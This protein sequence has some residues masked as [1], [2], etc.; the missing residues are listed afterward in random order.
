MRNI[1]SVLLWV[2]VLLL[3]LGRE[4]ASGLVIYRLGGEELPPPP[5]ADDPDV[6]FVQL[7]WSEVDAAQGGEIYQLDVDER[8]IRALEY[9]PQ[10]NVAPTSVDR[11]GKPILPALNGQVWDGDTTTVWSAERY[12]CIEFRGTAGH[13]CYEDFA[14]SG[15]TQIILGDGKMVL[16][17]VRILSGLDDP[18]GVVRTVRLFISSVASMPRLTSHSHPPARPHT[19]EIRNNSDPRLEI[20]LPPH[21]DG[22][23]LQVALGEHDHPWK[24]HDIEVYAKGFVDRSTY[25]SNRIDAQDPVAWGEIRWVGRKA[26]GAKLFVRTRSGAREEPLRYWKF[27]GNEDEKVEVTR[28]QYGRLKLGELGG[29]TYNREDWSFWSAPYDFADTVGT[30]VVSLRPR[31]YFQFK[32][33]FFPGEDGGGELDFLEVRAASPPLASELVAE[34]Y[35]FEVE[36]GKPTQFTYALRPVIGDKDIGFDRFKLTSSSSRI[37]AVETVRLGGV[38]V[39]F[40]EESLSED[41][42]VITLPAIERKDTAVLIEVVFQAIALRYGS[43][44]EARVFSSRHPLEVPQG[45]LPGDATDASAGNRLSVITSV[46]D[47]TR[48]RAE[49]APLVFT[50]NGDQ[51]NDGFHITYDLFEISGTGSVTVEIRDLSGRLVRQVYGGDD[52]VGHYRRAWDGKD[53]AGQLVLPG[54][55][56]YRVSVDTDEGEEDKVGALHV[57][58]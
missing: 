3:F 16:D 25:I 38:D 55:Y 50:P 43:T 6:D 22:T 5:E 12:L 45:V 57:A 10:V 15:T 7:S 56:L 36:P 24:V 48:L 9:D 41:E 26:P 47:K 21:E 2:V 13:L 8:V 40:T 32:V 11:G 34:I 52:P 17:R 23:F 19:V 53:Q 20:P 4:Q 42:V 44:F 35:P 46:E 14:Q 39:E 51:V 58:Y 1:A 18:A 54:V 29:T 33:D 27:I 37:L 30:T 49:V 28:S 31:R